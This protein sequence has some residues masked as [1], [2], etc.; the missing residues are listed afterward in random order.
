MK[1]ITIHGLDE[2][3]DARIREKARQQGASLNKTI[4]KLLAESLGLADEGNRNHRHDFADLCGV[5]SKEDVE[6]FHQKIEDLST[7][8]RQDW[9]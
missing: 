4:K 8:D 7:V 6:E 2:P 5:W 9:Q 1:S 3:L